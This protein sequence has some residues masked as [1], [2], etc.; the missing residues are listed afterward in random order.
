MP[1][2]IVPSPVLDDRLSVPKDWIDSNG[3]MNV[4]CYLKAFD[5]AFDEAYRLIGLTE[6]HMAEARGTTF[7][8]EH[9]ITYQ[10]E[11]FEGD[12]LRIASRLLA[13]D[14]K[15]MHWIQGM[16]HR[17]KGYL[18]ATCEW[19]ILYVDID[20]RRVGRFPPEMERR[21]AV[22]KAAHDRLPLPAE[23]G[24]RIEFGPRRDRAP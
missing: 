14:A 18:A 22:L 10:R 4:A 11:L 1:D 3:H 6:A 12:P 23:V 19:L 15:R 21:L 13:F 9:H 8:A 2:C 5:L 24:R 17:E 16:Y 7:A 20:R